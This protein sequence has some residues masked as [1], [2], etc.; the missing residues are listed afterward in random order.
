[1]RITVNNKEQLI[2]ESANLIL[3]LDTIGILEYS[4]IALAVNE[5]VISR[6][7]WKSFIIVENDKVLVIRATQGG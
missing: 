7:E 1:M 5:Q 2:E 4:G 6:T 3:L